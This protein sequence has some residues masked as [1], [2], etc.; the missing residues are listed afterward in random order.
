VLRIEARLA[1]HLGYISYAS[2]AT[3][4]LTWRVADFPKPPDAF[5]FVVPAREGRKII[6]G[7]F[8]SLKFQGRAPEGFVLARV[9]LGG[10]LQSEMMQLSDDQMV[11]A[12]RAEFRDL[13]GVRAAP[14][15]TE[16]QRWPAAMPQYAVG[17]LDR[18]ATIEQVA[19]QIPGLFVAGAAYRGVG[20]PDC[21]HSGENAAA[22]AFELL[23]AR[24]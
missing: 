13:L 4:N 23:A 15:M 2:A 7:S 10:V 20:V 9:F 24:P 16:V 14:G 3:V 8:S 6:A 21:V 1:D 12:A 5:G 22:A 18:V 11:S 17:H 19:A